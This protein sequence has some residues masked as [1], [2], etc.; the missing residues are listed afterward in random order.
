MG[1]YGY[2]PSWPDERRRLALIERIWDPV[3][4]ALLE[5]LGVSAGW[6][7]LDVGAGGGSIARWLRDR[8]GANGTVV[9]VD[10]DT[11][12]FEGEKGIEARRLD[13][14]TGDLERDAYDVV[15]CRLLLHHLRGKELDAVRR[16]VAALRPGG[17]L[18]ATEPYLGAMFSSPTPALAKMWRALDEA[19]PNANFMW[20]PALPATLEAAGLTEVEAEGKADVVRGG[21]PE[22]DVL[23]LTVK[24]VRERIP[25]DVD[26][27]AGL[28]LLNDPT[29]LEPGV[30]WYY[31]WG[32]R[33][34]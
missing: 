30:V 8:V 21:T 15:H 3:T 10:L 26:I 31:A 33:P 14:L 28:D 16:M 7:C 4:T 18:L 20:A 12:F 13:I 34:V 23:G 32:R 17:V 27:D 25:V 1:E 9:A 24:A 22:A 11:R 19:M 29:T 6:R 5:R 2:N